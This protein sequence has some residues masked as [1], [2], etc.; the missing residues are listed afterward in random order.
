MHKY[1]RTMKIMIWIAA[2][3]S[4]LAGAAG[5]A[6]E[7]AGSAV[8]KAHSALQQIAAQRPEELVSVIVQGMGADSLKAQ[9]AAIQLGGRITQDLAII[10]AF[11][12]E[13]P[14]AAAV[15]LAASPAVRWV[16]LNAPTQSA[17]A[18]PVVYTTWATLPGTA[19]ANSFAAQAAMVD[20]ALGPNDTYGY[21]GPVK[22]AFAGF[23]AEI[24]P[25]YAI[26]KVEVVLKGYVNVKLGAG[27]DPKITPYIGGVKGKTFTLNHHAYD[28]YIGQE[29]AGFVY[30]DITSAR[31]WKWGDF[32][33]NLQ[34]AI[35]QL[36]NGVKDVIYYDAIGLRVTSAPGSDATGDQAPPKLP[37]QAIN[38]SKIINAYNRSVRAPEVWN[39]APGYLQGQDFTVAVVDSGVIK[40]K[41]LGGR[42]YKN[43]NFNPGYHDSADRY[44]HGT[45]V[46][47][48][49]AGDGKHS[50]RLRVGNHL[51]PHPLIGQAVACQWHTD[52]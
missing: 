20:S 42:L 31:A 15:K 48:I 23:S 52:R 37:K 19:V 14:A 49:L 24:T 18:A 25:G 29:K 40:N 7:P 2:M 28:T 33:N 16:S 38:S 45:F 39:Q 12:V 32:A 6:M 17:Q 21:G 11:A 9:A 50:H 46:A 26:T 8:L 51:I 44:G 5:P 47:T 10:K 41:D 43:V 13:M 22:G 27:D 4:I 30:L 3:F 34:L 36:K 35:A 1:I